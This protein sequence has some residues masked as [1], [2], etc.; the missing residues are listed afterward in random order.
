MLVNA[1]FNIA[2][3]DYE[4]NNFH[5]LEY[6]LVN[7]RPCLFD[8]RRNENGEIYEDECPLPDRCGEFVLCEDSEC[9]RC[10]TLKGVSGWSK[11]CD[12]KSPGCYANGFTY[13]QLKGV[14]HFTVK[15]TPGTLPLKCSNYERKCTKD[16]KCCRN[17][18]V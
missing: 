5:R 10:P 9:V 11:N 2:K 16:C 13:Y 12:T 7:A 4:E 3:T 6:G 18:F 15:Y 17:P 1:T 14:D 8:N